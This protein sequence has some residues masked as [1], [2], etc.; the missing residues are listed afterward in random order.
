MPFELNLH[1]YLWIQGIVLLLG[2]G[3]LLWR[4]KRRTGLR[5]KLSTQKSGGSS[6]VVEFEGKSSRSLQVF[7]N[8]NGHTFEAYEAL[9]LPAGASWSLVEKSFK[10]QKTLA[11]SQSRPFLEAAFQALNS[12]LKSVKN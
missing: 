8:Y 11:D 7:F 12:S 3:F 2:L 6:A 10:E 5:L 1:N 4:P 9:G